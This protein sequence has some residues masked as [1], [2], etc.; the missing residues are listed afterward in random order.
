[1]RK[2]NYEKEDKYENRPD[3]VRNREARNRARA[4]ETKKLGHSPTG[5]VAHRVPLSGKG[6]SG[7]SNVHVETVKANRGWR[8]GQS[9][10]KVP[11]EK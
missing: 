2:R 6:S 9:G 4:H 11:T 7:D 3:Q 1:M 8:K 5:D 10:Y